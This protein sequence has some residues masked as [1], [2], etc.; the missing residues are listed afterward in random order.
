MAERDRD[1]GGRARNARPRDATGRPLPRG[2]E[3]VPGVS[4]DVVLGPAETLAQAQRLIDSGH[5]FHAHEVLEAAWKSA[6]EGD[7]DL[8]RG[9]AQ[10]AVGLTHAQRANARGAVALLHRGA[11][12]VRLYAQTAPHGIDIARLLAEASDLAERIERSGPDA[13]PEADLR[14]RLLPPA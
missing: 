9:L 3:G 10:L 5:P 12:R 7:R 2:S 11:E 1:S 8:W 6:Q 13:I 4:E 14:L